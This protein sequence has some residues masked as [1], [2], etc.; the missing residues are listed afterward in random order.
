MDQPTP[1]R[2]RQR[3]QKKET[4]SKPF[5]DRGIPNEV[6]IQT[7]KSKEPQNTSGIANEASWRQDRPLLLSPLERF[8]GK[9]IV[10]DQM[11]MLHDEITPFSSR[12][13]T[14]QKIP[15]SNSNQGSICLKMPKI[16]SENDSIENCTPGNKNC[17]ESADD[18]SGSEESAVP[19][20]IIYPDAPY[21]IVNGMLL[22]FCQ[23]IHC[24]PLFFR[25]FTFV[26]LH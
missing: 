8:K 24:C 12:K 19:I 25:F 4:T 7:H 21:S 22:V 10:P 26:F 11:N 5:S 14:L 6:A 15:G 20:A 1:S 9:D 16:E 18:I 3:L 23:T 13:Q 2:K 17:A